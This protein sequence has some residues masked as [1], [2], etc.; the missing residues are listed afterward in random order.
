VETRTAELRSA[1]A[2]MIVSR[3]KAMEAS[4]AKSEF[5]ANM[6][7]EIRTP[8]NGVVGMCQL[9]E[10]TKLTEEQREYVETLKVSSHNLL[11]IIND[12][13]DLSKI[14]ANKIALAAEEFN[15]V[16]CLDH[17]AKTQRP[18]LEGK[19]VALKVDL[20]DDIPRLVIG[21]EL[22]TQ[23]ILL[24]LLSNAVK[25]T[26]QG[27]VVF[28]ARI[29]EH[30]YGS[31]VLR[32]EVRD[33]GIGIP[34]DAQ[35]KIFDPFAQEGD[36][37]CRQFGGTGLGLTISRHLAESMGGSIVVDSLPGSG[38]CF[39]VTLPFTLCEGPQTTAFS[40]LLAGA[41]QEDRPLRI[42]LVDDHPINSKYESTLLGKLGHQVSMAQNGQECLALL[43]KETFELVLMDIQMPVMNGEQALQ[44]MRASLKPEVSGLPVIALTAYAM[45]GER[46]RFVDQG[47]D[48]YLSKPLVVDELLS[49]IRRIMTHRLDH[50]DG[51]GEES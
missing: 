30:R 49:E 10:M 1:N 13:L 24:N 35:G 38:S 4:R 9:L 40:G 27:E 31:V 16:Q 44:A 25:F 14:E 19:G 48:G 22:R 45:D 33:T 51:V 20:A 7:H 2:D 50:D 5:L 12:I 42:L 32:V 3:D 39:T 28:K 23:Q 41:T 37:I 17:V 21:D 11:S 47:F 43:A 8:M 6:S 46:S 29:A 36:S 15:L 34:P 18:L 26:R